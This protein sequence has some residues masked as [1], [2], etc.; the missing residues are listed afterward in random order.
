MSVRPPPPHSAPPVKSPCSPQPSSTTA[1]RVRVYCRG[2]T[3]RRTAWPCTSRVCPCR[4]RMPSAPTLPRPAMLRPGTWHALTRS[5]PLHVRGYPWNYFPFSLIRPSFKRWV[6]L[7]K[8][9]IP[10]IP[11]YSQ[12]GFWSDI[13]S[14]PFL[15][16]HSKA[17]HRKPHHQLPDLTWLALPYLTPLHENGTS[18][19]FPQLTT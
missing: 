4:S 19:M 16:Q 14:L 8:R 7:D 1:C 2:N 15:C 5:C 12:P 6:R 17:H 18:T 9:W 3:F 13:V 10:S 11:P